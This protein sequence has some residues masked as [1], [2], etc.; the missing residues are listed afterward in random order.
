MRPASDLPRSAGSRRFSGRAVLIVLGLVFFLVTVFGRGV[1]GF[2][3]DLWWHRGL[4]RTDVFWGQLWAKLLLFGVAL[5]AFV[6]LAGVNLWVADR[7]APKVFPANVH[8]VVQRFHELF[9]RR[10]RLVR[11]AT[12]AILGVLVALPATQQW[13]DWLLFRNS[14]SFG[15]AD[16]QFGADVGFY[17][18]QL[19][20]LT[21]ALD[22]LFAAMVL[23]LLFTVAAHL[24]NGAVLFAGVTPTIR[25][26]SKV[27]VAVLLAVMAILRAGDYWLSRYELTNETRGFVQ[28]ATYTVVNAQLPALM[29]L[30]LIALLTALLFLASIRTNSWRLPLVASA[31]WLVVSIIGGVAYPAL[32]QSLVVRPNQAERELPYIERNVAATRQAMGLDLV[33]TVPVEFSRL[34]ADE[35]EADLEPI[36][37]V[38][39]LTPGLMLSRFAIDRGETAGLQIADLD[40]DRYEI[41]GEREQVLVAARELDLDGIPNQSWQ[42]RHL[43]STRGCGLI[44]APVSRVTNSLRPDYRNVDLD[45]PELYFSPEL[46]GYAVA[47][48]DVVEAQCGDGSAYAG[49]AGIELSG[50]VRR[51]VTALAFLDYNLLASGAVNSDS[52]LLMIRDVRDR[53]EKLAPF[54]DYDG[55]PYPVE[56]DG[57]V[58]WVID[59]YS[60][61]SRYPYAQS[62]GNVQLSS[63]TGL[64]RSANYV[65]NAVKA[66]V[67]A[68][69]GE[70]RFYVIDP[71]DP[72]IDAWQGA[73]PDLFTPIEE[74]PSELSDNLRYPEDL[75]RLQ[76][77]LYSKYQIAAEDFFQRTGAWSVAQAPSIQ[78]RGNL[79]STA[80]SNAA[81]TEEFAT[82]T[83]TERFMPYY[84]LF[85]N[86]ATGEFEFVILRPF[87]P[88]STDDRRTELQAYMT[89]SSDQGSYGRLTS[90]VVA[91]EPLP[92][93]PLRVATQAESE[94]LISRE[95][96]FQDNE[97]SG[98]DVVFGDQQLVPVGDGLL[99]VRPFYVAIEGITEYRFVI[100]S[101]ENRATFASTLSEALADLF[102]GFDGEIAE[103]V[104]SA[105]DGDVTE[106][107]ERP[108]TV[109]GTDSGDAG[110]PGDSGDEPGL[111]VPDTPD[112]RATTAELL[113]QAE[114]LF[115]EADQLLRDGD[116][117]AYQDTI[118]RA[119]QFVQAAIDSL[120]PN[121]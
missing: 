119:E 98:T 96:S 61:T 77:E 12:A 39:L 37:N 48:T 93:G 51:A 63:S 99:Y 100:V 29:L 102:P 13:Q 117:G 57:G 2:V 104:A 67:D 9:G 54:L 108:D 47:R 53:V 90:Y 105:D 20:F 62:I 60:S 6:L 15:V 65:R 74:M 7:V 5:L 115:A 86:P 14:R 101:Y 89:A 58:Q 55:D 95:I 35:V 72:I 50:P 116:L 16:A 19:P 3:L 111:V 118:A 8:P 112:E 68:Y 81:G 18:F 11:Y 22:W 64:S 85:R 91:Q 17:V 82:E 107:V 42:G 103:R 30:T 120:Q 66:T 23:V 114:A 27:H 87:V 36:E 92:S 88:F 49:T 121:D 109:D 33:E 10:L 56:V 78:P 59:G 24:L 73:F 97:E 25:Q 75:F 106:P 80:V 83:N 32:V 26:A 113:L 94:Q 40:V 45:R 44:M 31:L 1:A 52:Q 28:G 4:E 84:S 110:D 76:T 79:T 41:D 69:T 70:V 21:F 34:S 71:E 46:K 38:R 43:V